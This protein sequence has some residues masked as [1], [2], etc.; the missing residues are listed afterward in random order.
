MRML[1][2]SFIEGGLSAGAS[3]T[4]L[5]LLA[6]SESGDGTE[7]DGSEPLGALV[8]DPAGLLDLPEGYAYVVLERTGDLMSDGHPVGGRPD[9]MACFVGEG[10]TYVLMRNH[11]VDIGPSPD[12][13]VAY[14]PNMLG[15]VSR[16]VL[17]RDTLDRTSSNYVLV[18]TTRNCAG[19]PSPFGWLSC[20]ESDVPGHGYV[21][22]C[23]PQASAAAPPQRAP[24][25]GRFKHEAVA[26]DPTTEI[27]YLTE[28]EGQSAFYRH[29]PRDGAFV[30]ELQA[31]KIVGRDRVSLTEGLSL[32]DTFDIEWVA[33][34]DPEGDPLGT[35]EQAFARG[36]AVVNRGE[37]CWFHEGSV[38]FVSTEGG[39]VG[40]GQVFRLD[41]A[42]EGGTLTLIAQAEDTAA[43]VNP[44]NITVSPAG[45]V[46][47]VEDNDGPNH[48]RRIEVDGRVETLARNALDGGVSEFCGVCFS[49]DGRV[50]FV[51]IQE[52]G[53]TLA[54][55]GPFAGA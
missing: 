29:V 13:M 31:M 8:S 12:P 25:W 43:L 14:D 1:R 7:T 6:C 48:I 18:G 27:A 46:F 34:D 50:M 30:G 52:P 20:E 2:R 19:G 15:G 38:F 41:P 32:G 49:P 17:N 37:G 23:D 39:P 16:L 21:F 44:D 35:A 22:L 28:D 45:E 4:A 42:A 40:L 53:I 55:T 24:S 36:A 26:F 3:P 11:E 54:I 5:A 10:N 47:V 51:N 9:G 33:I